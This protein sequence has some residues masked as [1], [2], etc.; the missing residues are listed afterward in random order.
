MGRD[1]TCA[2][3]DFQ[4]L[5]LRLGQNAKIMTDDMIIVKPQNQLGIQIK[6]FDGDS[7]PFALHISQN[8]VASAPKGTKNTKLKL[9]SKK[10]KQVFFN[11]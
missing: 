9:K 4:T 3:D 8:I 2:F 1:P 6:A 5:R 10:E 11:F 7:G